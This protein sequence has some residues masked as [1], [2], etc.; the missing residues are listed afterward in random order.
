MPVAVATPAQPKVKSFAEWCEQKNSV[1]TAIKNT[2][3][4]LLKQSKTNNC[5]LADTNLNN[6]IMLELREQNIRD[7][8]PLTSLTNLEWL[9]LDLNIK[10][11]PIVKQDCP[12]LD[13]NCRF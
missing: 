5:Q 8:Q 12:F 13:N 10:N 4:V 7:L 11:N 2:I 1:S 3:E 9:V 6:L